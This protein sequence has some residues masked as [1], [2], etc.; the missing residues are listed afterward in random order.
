M[1]EWIIIFLVVVILAGPITLSPIAYWLIGKGRKVSKVLKIATYV[2]AA[3]MLPAIIATASI[4]LGL[5]GAAGPAGIAILLAIFGL[6]YLL[7]P[8]IILSN[9][10]IRKPNAEETWLLDVL[11]DVKKVSGYNKKVDLYIANVDMPNAFA[12]SNVFKR[13]IVVHSGLLNTLDEDE[14]KAVIAHELGHIAHNDNTYALTASLTPYLTYV[15]GFA[16]LL[17][18]TYMVMGASYISGE[19]EEDGGASLLTFFGGILISLFGALL[20]L[21]AF[22]ANMGLLGFSRIREHLADMY[23]VKSTRSAKLVDALRKIV[24]VV[25][26]LKARK[27]GIWQRAKPDLK[28]MLYIIPAIYSDI[29]GFVGYLHWSNPFSTHPPIEAREYIVKKYCEELARAFAR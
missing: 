24:G 21:M 10:E 13:A 28:K 15:I 3:L 26:N 7:F 8:Y 25:E 5:F 14:V 23:S 9:T 29:F 12:I 19:R 20:M 27:E 1:I 11:E 22:I 6:Q 2:S 4:P 18:G 17:T 16:I